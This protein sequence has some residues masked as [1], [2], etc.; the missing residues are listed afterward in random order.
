MST[1]ASSFARV[2][3][4]SSLFDVRSGPLSLATARASLRSP[5]VAVFDPS[6]RAA[7]LSVLNSRGATLALR[8]PKVAPAVSSASS[9][10]S[11]RSLRPFFS[12]E[13]KVKTLVRCLGM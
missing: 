4:L 3:L 8:R 6:R 11:D 7:S 2:V 5:P 13:I 9:P 1:F 10:S 12:L